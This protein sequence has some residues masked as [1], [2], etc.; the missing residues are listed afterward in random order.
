MEK[1]E[2]RNTGYLAQT[3]A[4]GG[5]LLVQAGQLINGSGIV[6]EKSVWLTRDRWS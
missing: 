4:G 3:G 5:K 1:R 2:G 6:Y